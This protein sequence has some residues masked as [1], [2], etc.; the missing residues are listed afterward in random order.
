MMEGIVLILHK[1]QARDL[2]FSEEEIKYAIKHKEGWLNENYVINLP[3]EAK[4]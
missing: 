3:L 1:E 4:S 2:G